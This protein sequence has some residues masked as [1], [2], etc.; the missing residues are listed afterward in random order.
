[1]SLAGGRLCNNRGGPYRRM[2][3]IMMTVFAILIAAGVVVLIYAGLFVVV[4]GALLAMFALDTR[5]PARWRGAH[6]RHR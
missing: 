5:G 4:W 2:E 6:S 3:V 1:M